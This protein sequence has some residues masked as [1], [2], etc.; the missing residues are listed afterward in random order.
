MSDLQG[1]DDEAAEHGGTLQ[2]IPISSSNGASQLAC[3]HPSHR[4]VRLFM[5]YAEANAVRVRFAEAESSKRITV[6]A[7]NRNGGGWF[8]TACKR[9]LT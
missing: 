3:P 9:C 1:D 4:T 5:P 2:Y 7:L 6:S 8:F